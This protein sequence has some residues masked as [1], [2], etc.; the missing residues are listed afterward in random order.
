MP[1]GRR[2]QRTRRGARSRVLTQVGAAVAVGSF[3]IGSFAAAATP[4]FDAPEATTVQAD[5]AALPEIATSADDAPVVTTETK[6]VA[7]K[8]DSVKE[9]DPDL[10]KGVEEVVTEGEPGERVI[11][12]DVT[13]VDGEEVSR[14]ETLRLTVS[15]PTDEVI[16]VGTKEEV[17]EESTSSSSGSSVP[18]TST[19][20][21]GSSRAIGQQLA[22]DMYGW[23]GDQWSCLDALWQKESGWNPNAHNPSSGAHGIPQ[24]LPG[25]KMASA[26]SDWAT[27]P[28]TQIRWGLGY[29]KARYGTPCSAWGHSQSV[30]WY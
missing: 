21:A 25:S 8:P 2:E 13:Y 27:N 29:I 26:G 14:V 7:I 18:A 15:Q 17:V 11:T 10:E 6:S 24:A 4:V 3:A 20:S 1:G 28:A 23:S 12:Y 30:G 22:A 16:A 9:D 5:L 19:V